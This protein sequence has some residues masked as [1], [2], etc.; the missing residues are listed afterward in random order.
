MPE[1]NGKH[2]SKEELDA[3]FEK[4]NKPAVQAKIKE[5]FDQIERGEY[6]VVTMEEL[7]RKIG[8]E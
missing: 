1:W 2:I 3:K 6:V 8:L 7:K 4:F 5:G